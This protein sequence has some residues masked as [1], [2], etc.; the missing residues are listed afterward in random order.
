[1]NPNEHKP[2]PACPPTPA[3]DVRIVCRDTRFCRMLE[4]EISLLGLTV[5]ALPA[6]TP[7]AD[8][9][10][11]AAMSLWE[12]DAAL[13]LLDLD[14]FPFP[15]PSSRPSGCRLIGWSRNPDALPPL[16]PGAA[17]I[18]R[19]PFALTDLRRAVLTCLPDSADRRPVRLPSRVSPA[20]T[21]HPVPT[22]PSP[23]L[24]RSDREGT[25]LL[26]GQELPLTPYEWLLFSHLSSHPGET[27]P[28]DALR[29]LLGDVGGNT[30]EV[31]ICRLRA[32][33]EK[34]LGIRLIASVRRKGYRYEGTPLDT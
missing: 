20:P 1:M 26:D 5:S 27:I 2:E 6:D 3:T 19:R 11:V 4:A 8:E 10:G 29:A 18:L 32:K 15:V 30:V 28:R 24:T 13:L 17:V 12:T 22:P 16:P 33:L 31:Y 34:P 7:A 25:L 14:E 21:E 9:D 23:R